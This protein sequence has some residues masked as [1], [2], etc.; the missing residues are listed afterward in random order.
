[1]KQRTLYGFIMSLIV[2]MALSV[3]AGTNQLAKSDLEYSVE[4][5]YKKEIILS[6]QAVRVLD[7]NAV[8]LV[9]TSNFNSRNAPGNSW[10]GFGVSGTHDAYSKVVSGSYLLIA[11][12]ET[13]KI[14]TLGGELSVKEII[15]GLN[16]SDIAS[17]LHTIDDQG[18]VIGH[19]KYAGPLCS[20]LM[21]EVKKVAS[22]TN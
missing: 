2:L 10:A 9:E 15:I 4:L 20:M 18:R 16:R 22:K 13:R 11:F 8:Q 14:K 17:S 6:P 12:S 21:D 5:H 3:A 1:M 19:G 7:S